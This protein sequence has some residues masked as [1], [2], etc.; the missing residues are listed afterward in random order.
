MP[1]TS[2]IVSH[3]ILFPK[4]DQTVRRTHSRE[5][6]Y[7]YKNGPKASPCS[8]RASTSHLSLSFQS[9]RANSCFKHCQQLRKRPL[10]I[11]CAAAEFISTYAHLVSVFIWLAELTS[12]FSWPVMILM[13]SFIQRPKRCDRDTWMVQQAATA[14]VSSLLAVSPLLFFFFLRLFVFRRNVSASSL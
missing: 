12:L 5:T 11:C 8:F 13:T 2:Y 4:L 6:K 1:L 7:R 14:A 10:F 3:I 9:E